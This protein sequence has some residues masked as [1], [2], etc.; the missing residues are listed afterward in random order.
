[1]QE[2]Y[3]YMPESGTMECYPRLSEELRDFY[4]LLE[5]YKR[6]KTLTNKHFLEKQLNDLFFAVK[7]LVVSGELTRYEAD[8]IQDYIGGLFDDQ[9]Q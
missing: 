2:T 7:H 4:D 1:M 9:L 5:K 3:R 6:D 8:E